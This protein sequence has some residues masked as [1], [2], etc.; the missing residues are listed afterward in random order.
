MRVLLDCRMTG[1][2]GVG[3]YTTGLTRALAARADVELI[4]V[5]A[6]HE[7]PPAAPGFLI[8]A[9]LASAHPFTLRGALELGRIVRD[10]QPDLVHCLHFPTPLPLYAPLVV[11]LHDLIPLLA[12]GV[13]PSIIRRAAYRLWNAR[14]A[15]TAD[16]LIVPS[17]TTASDVTRL[18]PTAR[19]KLVMTPYA[20]DDFTSGPL[21]SLQGRLASIASPPYLLAIGNTKPHKELRTL[22]RAFGVLAPTFPELRLVLVGTEPSGYLRDELAGIPTEISGRVAFA[23]SVS[24]AELR[25]LYADASVFVFPSRQEG[26]G[27]PPLEAMALGAPVVCADAASLPEVVG[28]AAVMFP[29]GDQGGLVGA[30]ARVIRDPAFR[31]ILADKGRKRAAQFTWAATAAA[32]TAVYRTVLE[33]RD[34]SRLGW[35]EEETSN[36]ARR[37]GS[38]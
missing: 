5:C 11:T 25:A 17:E 35:E 32:T 37:G 2:S 30:L 1:W 36:H 20:V 7:A 18:F 15:S 29:A 33:E 3:R 6:E 19:D 28:E 23:G 8:R 38:T 34:V 21:A 4:Q 14:A 9:M 27:L 26:F 16:R 31:R 22:L 12:P 13:M 24:D 10:T